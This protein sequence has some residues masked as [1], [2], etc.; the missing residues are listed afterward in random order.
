MVSFQL[1][2]PLKKI[3]KK[4]ITKIVTLLFFVLLLAALLFINFE[5]DIRSLFDA[6]YFA[7]VTVSTVGYGDITAKTV[8]GRL[9]SIF[10]IFSGMILISSFTATMSSILISKKLKEGQGVSSIKGKN[11]VVLCGW[12]WKAESLITSLVFSGLKNIILIN[13]YDPS[14]INAVI[15]KFDDANIKFIKGDFTDHNILSKANLEHSKGVIIVPDS[16]IA[17]S[18]GADEKTVF[19][20]MTV[21][22]I[23]EKIKVHVQLLRNETVPYIQRAKA[24]NYFISENT[25]PFFLTSAIAHPGITDVMNKIMT[26]DDEDCMSSAEIPKEFVG[27]TFGELSSHFRTKTGSILI[28]LVQF[29]DVLEMKNID[30]RDNSSIDAFIKRKFEEAGRLTKDLDKKKVMLNP[31]DSYIIKNFEMAVIIQKKPVK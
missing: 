30:S 26:F 16:S 31:G 1:I 8:P 21:K 3:W 28:A 23:S 4:D 22:S 19:A 29:Q 15:D 18:Q 9:V 6:V 2:R 7:V 17:S 11:F 27:R 12:N 25:I 10:L 14:Q 24:D 5:K 13:D 20:T